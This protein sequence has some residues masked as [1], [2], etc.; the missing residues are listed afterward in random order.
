MLHESTTDIIH[1]PSILMKGLMSDQIHTLHTRWDEETGLPSLL[2]ECTDGE[3]LTPALAQCS[4]ATVECHG[5]ETVDKISTLAFLLF[6]LDITAA[7]IV[8]RS[9]CRLIILIVVIL[10]ISK[11]GI[12]RLLTIHRITSTNR[13]TARP[14]HIFLLFMKRRIIH[15]FCS[16]RCRYSGWLKRGIVNVIIC[17]TGTLYGESCAHATTSSNDSKYK[18]EDEDDDHTR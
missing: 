15:R 14:I 13:M 3:G 10:I 11:V 17:G 1:I 6:S 7:I 12:I 5:H 18:E 16:K 4:T 2:G 9:N 8:A